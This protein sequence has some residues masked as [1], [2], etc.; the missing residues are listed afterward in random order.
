MAVTAQEAWEVFRRSDLLYGQE[1]IEAA[2]TR[3]AVEIT[4]A[5][6]DLDPLIICVLNGGLVPLGRLLPQLHFPLQTDYIHASRYGDRLVG[7]ELAWNAGPATSPSGRVVLLVDD[8][9]DEGTTLVSLEQWLSRQR[10]K[11]VYKAVL[12]A[13]RKAKPAA[14]TADFV[15]LEV[16]D[17]YVFGYGMDY[18]GYLRNLP[19]IHAAAAGDEH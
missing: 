17:R 9:L 5:L 12:V 6:K 14:T 18:E 7:G 8:I 4:R 15:A 1:E 3:I 19:G 16:P 2:L 10:A 13:K 11:A